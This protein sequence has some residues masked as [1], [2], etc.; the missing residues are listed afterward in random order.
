MRSA[1]TDA[2]QSHLLPP[3][4]YLILGSVLRMEGRHTV[5]QVALRLCFDSPALVLTQ[6]ILFRLD[7]RLQLPQLHEHGM[8]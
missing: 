2:A 7:L 8:T 3:R 6:E 4:R 5:R 1:R